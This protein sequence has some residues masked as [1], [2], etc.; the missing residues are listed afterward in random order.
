MDYEKLAD[1]LFPNAKPI[2]YWEEKFPRRN[3]ERI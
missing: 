2:E 1:L 3:K